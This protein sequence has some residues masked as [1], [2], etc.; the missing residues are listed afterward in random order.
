[1]ADVTI[2]REAKLFGPDVLTVKANVK[3][4]ASSGPTGAFKK[5][6]P[7][8]LATGGAG[9]E[10]VTLANVKSQTGKIGIIAEDIADIETGD[11]VKVAFAGHVYIEGVRA[12]GLTSTQCSDLVLMNMAGHIV[13]VDEKEV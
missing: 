1:M 10:A 8:F 9:Y 3:A 5:G 7:V 13:F 2:S 4:V 11:D 6:T 12:A